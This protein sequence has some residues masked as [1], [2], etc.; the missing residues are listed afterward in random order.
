M[1]FNAFFMIGQRC[2]GIT[3]GHGLEVSSHPIAARIQVGGPRSSSYRKLQA[4]NS[5]ITETVHL[6][7][8]TDNVRCTVTSQRCASL[9][10]ESVIPALKARRCDKTAVISRQFPSTWPPR[11]YKSLNPCNFWLWR[12]LSPWSTVIPS[13]LYPTLKE[14]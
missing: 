7:H 5:V 12:Y 1:A 8:T 10:K 11:S 2:D 6:F 14:E 9:S 4:D 3:G 13:H